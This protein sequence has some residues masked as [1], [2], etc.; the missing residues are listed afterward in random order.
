MN[1]NRIEKT[2]ILK[3][4]RARVWRAI[5]N[6]E[7]FGAWFG[8]KFEGAF[9]AGEE[10]AGHITEPN[11]YAGVP[12]TIVVESV[13]PESLFSYRWHP[14]GGDEPVDYSAE[15]MT[16]VEFRLEEVPGGTRLT[17]TESGFEHVGAA[18]RKQALEGNSEGW[19]IQLER[20]TSY[21]AD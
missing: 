15:P 20:I 6:A 18:R 13:E 21:V 10:L 9:V 11:E 4:P 17:I 14:G 16:L 12:M 7:E 5:A 3:A 1:T 2:A 19:S 8:A